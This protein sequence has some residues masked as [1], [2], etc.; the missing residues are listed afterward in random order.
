MCPMTTVFNPIFQL[1]FILLFLSQVKCIQ[2][3]LIAYAARSLTTVE[4][5]VE[6]QFIRL[7]VSCVIAFPEQTIARLMTA[8]TSQLV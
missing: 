5:T 1:I 7:L 3:P 6:M 2:I 4:D 8:L